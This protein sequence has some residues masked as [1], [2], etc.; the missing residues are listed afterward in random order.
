MQMI[1]QNTVEVL[2][3]NR[4]QRSYS[5]KLQ[6]VTQNSLDNTFP[7]ELN[8]DS[9]RLGSSDDLDFLPELGSL[10]VY[11]FQNRGTNDEITVSLCGSDISN[12]ILRVYQE[13]GM[14]LATQV[15]LSY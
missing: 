1:S 4:S 6:A 10:V 9:S 3:P 7:I 13:T 5:R 2:Q 8:C 11:R 15:G 14:F 12:N